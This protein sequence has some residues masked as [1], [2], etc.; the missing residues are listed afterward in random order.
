MF[1]AVIKNGLIVD[2]TRA[3]PYNAALY[4][5]D[6]KIAEI[7]ADA[8]KPAKVVYDAAGHMV[9]PGFIDIHSHSD[10]SYLSTPT[11]EAKLIGGVT[12]ELVGQCGIS[13]VPMNDRNLELN[14]SCQSSV[15]KVRPNK[16][17]YAPRDMVGYKKDVEEHGISINVGALIGHGALRSSVIGWEM[18]QMTETELKEMCDLLDKMLEQGAQKRGGLALL[19]EPCTPLSYKQKQML[20]Y[21]V[22]LALEVSVKRDPRDSRAPNEL[23]DGNLG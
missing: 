22:L 5:K 1:D 14:L 13:I 9:A 17:S 8:D 15:V 11:M 21:H 6:G 7:S 12:F 3:K 4:I 23:G 16:D 18:R 20:P 2:G 19:L 10:I